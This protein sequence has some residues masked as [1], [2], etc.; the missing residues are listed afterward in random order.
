MVKAGAD[1]TLPKVKLKVPSP[2]I[3]DTFSSM[4]DDAGLA[5]GAEQLVAEKELGL[6]GIDVGNGKPL[7]V[8]FENASRG[9]GMDMRVPATAHEEP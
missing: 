2:T 5:E 3:G 1:A 7:A 4:G 6:M 8:G 9:D